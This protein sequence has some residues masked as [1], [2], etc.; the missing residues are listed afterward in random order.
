MFIVG[1]LKSLQ[2]YCFPLKNTTILVLLKSVGWKLGF[3]YYGNTCIYG[4]VTVYKITLLGLIPCAVE[5]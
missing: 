5:N 3:V 4:A 1:N 2:L